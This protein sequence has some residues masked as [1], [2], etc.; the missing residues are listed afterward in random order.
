M[1][2]AAIPSAF[3]LQVIFV[4]VKVFAKATGSEITTPS[5]MVHPFASST[6]IVYAPPQRL[7]AS[8]VV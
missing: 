5:D 8:A 6:S 1:L 2:V 7:I 4:I 3:P